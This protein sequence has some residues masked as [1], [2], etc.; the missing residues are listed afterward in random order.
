M[1]SLA[2]YAAA[3]PSHRGSVCTVCS[4]E[5]RAEIDAAKNAGVVSVT[6]MLAWLATEGVDI[7]RAKINHHFG[8]RHHL[9][10]AG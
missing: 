10:A 1:P 5:Q 8:A 2:D 4:L 6:Q 7:S 3:N 9:Q